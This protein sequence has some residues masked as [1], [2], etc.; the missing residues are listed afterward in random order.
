MA[1]QHRPAFERG[2]ALKKM[3][4]RIMESV[5]GRAI[6]PV[7]VKVGGFYRA[8]ARTEI[9]ALAGPSA[10][11]SSSPCRPWSGWQDSSFPTSR[12]TTASLPCASRPATRSN[13]VASGSSDGLGRDPG[14]TSPTSW[15]RSMWRAHRAAGPLGGSTSIPDWASGT[16]RPQQSA[17]CRP[18]P[19]RPRP[20]AGLGP[21][22]TNPFQSIV[23]RAVE[24]V[25][26]CHEALR[27][28]DDY[29]PPDPP[30]ATCRQRWS[31]H[32]RHRGSPRAALPPLSTSILRA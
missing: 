28:V 23:V 21:V 15:W 22:C 5:G 20:R 27:L 2:L 26:A 9:A 17:S 7:N 29:A 30:A 25:F 19:A 13:R 16:L 12:A 10:E 8:P 14:R 3:G 6:H 4:N 32:R 1:Q 11:R 24:V 18:S 31:R